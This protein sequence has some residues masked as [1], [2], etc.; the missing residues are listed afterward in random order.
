[1]VGTEKRGWGRFP[2]K[3]VKKTKKKKKKKKAREW[4]GVENRSWTGR[5]GAMSNLRKEKLGTSTKTPSFSRRGK[6]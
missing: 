5:H 3:A 2:K 4:C 6:K 1:M